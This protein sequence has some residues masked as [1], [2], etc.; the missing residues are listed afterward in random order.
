MNNMKNDNTLPGNTPAIKDIN[1]MFHDLMES[2]GDL[3]NDLIR[4]REDGQIDPKGL[5]LSPDPY[6]CERLFIEFF[7][8]DEMENDFLLIAKDFFSHEYNNIKDYE[9]IEYLNHDFGDDWPSHMLIRFTLNLM[10]NAVNSGSEY[11]KSLFIYLYKTYYKKEFK[12]IK[13]FN[14]ISLS[15]LMSL[16]EPDGEHYSYVAN[17]SRILFIAGLQ[18]YTISEDCNVVY[19]YLNQFCDDM[20]GRDVYGFKG[21]EWKGYEENFREIEGKFDKKKIYALDAKI[22]KYLGNV[23]KWLGYCPEYVDLCDENEAG[24]ERRFAIVLTLLKKSFPKNEQ[25][26]SLEELTLYGMILHCV[27]ALTSNADWFADTLR[28][29]AYGEEGTFFY[30]DFP[31][32]F[33]PEDI[34]PGE[35]KQKNT[36]V[37]K[38]HAST[39]IGLMKK[40][41][42]SDNSALQSELE[43]LRKKVH[44]LESDN[45]NLRMNVTDKRRI[46]SEVKELREQIQ[47]ANSELAALRNYAYNMTEEDAPV[48]EESVSDM[49]KK[50]S[51]L[52]IVVIGGHS[53]WIS[54]I[55]KEFPDWIFVNPKASGSTDASIVDNADYVYFFTDTISHSNYY[56]FLN[57]LREHKLV[58]GY[59]HGVNVEKNI[60]DIYRDIFINI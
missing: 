30:D 48:S 4:L 1:N 24:L 54:K 22:S 26:F 60:R 23:L 25:E 32:Q 33:H 58:F 21:N 17:L 15:E 55:Q 50:L 35:N 34:I 45:K 38:Q 19:A 29:L 9:D 51:D 2:S 53:N 13:K 49:K 59:I 20:D 5:N 37:N 7:V 47:A 3:M 28:V 36:T 56:K 31:P 18:G 16:A 8:N 42:D 46:E 43:M 41:E 12:T 27:S 44:S 6:G 14:S 52:R 10:L 40:E 11:T 39:Q 57:V